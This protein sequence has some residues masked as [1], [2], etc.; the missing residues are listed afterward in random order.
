MMC[1]VLSNGRTITAPTLWEGLKAAG[2]ESLTLRVNP[3]GTGSFSVDYAATE[4]YD[5]RLERN[6]VVWNFLGE[7]AHVP[8][9]GK[10]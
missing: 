10:Q 6:V 8:E 1:L 3:T 9:K 2:L 5:K 4:V 7:F